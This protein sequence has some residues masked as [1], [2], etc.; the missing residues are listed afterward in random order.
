MSEIWYRYD[1]PWTQG[2]APFCQEMTV[3]RH[4]AKC[5]VFNDYGLD[6]FVLKDPNGR[7]YAYP[8]KELALKSYI[9]RKQRQMQHAAAT[10]DNAKR[11]LEIARMIESGT[12]VPK[13]EFTLFDG[14]V[15]R[16]DW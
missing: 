8:T 14:T 2:E 4:T 9:I 1:D 5:V 13:P 11:N 12:I 10:H 16:V 7:R 6:R 3:A 15:D